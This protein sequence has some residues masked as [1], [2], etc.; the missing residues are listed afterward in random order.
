MNGNVG[1]G[2]VRYGR[3]IS[4]T[5]LLQN[6]AALEGLRSTSKKPAAHVYAKFKRH[7]EP[8]ELATSS[9]LKT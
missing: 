1:T 2:E 6:E 4:V 9:R 8:V 3:L 7:V 5:L